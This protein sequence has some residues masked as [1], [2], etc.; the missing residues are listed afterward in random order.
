MDPVRELDKIQEEIDKLHSRSNNN[1]VKLA[2]LEAVEKERYEHILASIDKLREDMEEINTSIRSL[3]T[4]ATEGKTSLKTLLWVGGFVTALVSF[5]LM[6]YSYI[7][8]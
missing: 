4:L 6:L 7:P 1:K 3:Q 5:L 8:K 2:S